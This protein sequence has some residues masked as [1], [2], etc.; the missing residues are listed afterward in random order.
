M[1]RVLSKLS[2][3]VPFACAVLGSA[4]LSTV[5][6]QTTKVDF[7]RDVQPIL[8][9]QCISCH[10]PA[11]QMRGLRLDR[12]RDALPNRVG[13]N[14]VTIVPGNGA[15]SRLYQRVSGT[16][17]GLQ[18][19][20]TGALTPEQI[21]T[22]K[23]WID[24]GA[25][26]PDNYSGETQPQPSDP[27]AERMMEALRNG[28]RQKF[29]TILREDPRVVGRYG[30]G[31]STPL[32]YAA[33]YGDAAAVRMLLENGADPNTL[34]AGKATALMYAVDD[35]EKT[36]LLLDHGADPNIRSEEGR[37][38]LVIAA[39]RAGASPVVKL[40]LQHGADPTFQVASGPGTLARAAGSADEALIRL[41]LESRVART[42]LPLSIAVRPG[43]SACFN[44]LLQ[45]ADRNDLNAALTVAL[46]MGDAHMVQALIDR[47]AEVPANALSTLTVPAERIPVETIKHLIERGAAVNSPPTTAGSFLTLARRQG[48]A[49]LVDVLIKAGAKDEPA[50]NAPSLKPGPAESARAAIVRSIPPLQRADVS[51]IRKAGC[52][53]CHNNSLTAMGMAAARQNGIPVDETIARS[54]L[55]AIASFLDANRERALQGVG[56][57]GGLDTAGYILL[58]MAAE[59]YPSDA[60]TDAWAQYLKNLQLADGRWWVQTTRPP[61][62]SSTIQTTAA[63]MRSIQIYGPKSRR[64]E[65][66]AAVQRAAQWLER[67]QPK[68][69]EDF[70]FQLL[71]LQWGGGNREV[72]RKTS[73][74]LLAEQ[75]RDG[76]WGQLPWLASDAYATGQALVALKQSGALAV[77]APAYRRGVQFLMNSQLEDGSWHVKTRAFPAQPY[78]DSDFPHGQDQ[79]ISAAAT[80]WAV[81][82]LAPAAR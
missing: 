69:T 43:C 53:S 25:E 50:T 79:F 42:P 75:R 45:L 57:P 71:G 31:G 81:M 54:Q 48:E 60:I 9:E 63:A 41:L 4:F 36:R 51:F 11:Q 30:P 27:Q 7:G 29:A 3:I 47:G 68:N 82:A 14:G 40:L 26:W 65:Y 18:M 52:V 1:E 72:I 5:A 19:P 80:N 34:N 66:E 20:P 6:G 10:G 17:A 55:R 59:K 2:G 33:L 70:V 56:I 64:A 77:T 15:G 61:L 12:R 38:A 49:A 22:I 37:T 35:V 78:F 16:Q 67:A 62:E 46:R 58:G 21:N 74:D 28:D 39:G 23:L 44:A 24:E 13:A 8:R 73:R 32:M 76:G